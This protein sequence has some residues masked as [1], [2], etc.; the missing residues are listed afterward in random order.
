MNWNNLTPSQERAIPNRPYAVTK[1]WEMFQ[2]FYPNGDFAT[3]PMAYDM[4]RRGIKPVVIM[5]RHRYQLIHRLDTPRPSYTIPV[6][7]SL[8]MP[9]GWF[10]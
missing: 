3:R 6:N 10:R 9:G 8:A 2:Y 1:Q 5:R 7:N 4:L